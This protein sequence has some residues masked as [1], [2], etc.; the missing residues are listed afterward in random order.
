MRQFRDSFHFFH[1]NFCG[2]SVRFH[3]FNCV[4]LLSL[5]TIGKPVPITRKHAAPK[6]KYSRLHIPSSR[7]KMPFQISVH[8][9]SQSD[10]MRDSRGSHSHRNR[11]SSRRCCRAATCSTPTASPSRTSARA[12]ATRN[13]NHKQREQQAHQ[14]NSP[15]PPQHPWQQKRTACQRQQSPAGRGLE[16]RRSRCPGRN[17]QSHTPRCA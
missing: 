16:H 9:Q 11:V 10:R 12:C 13:G 4:V 5:Q 1:C 2:H 15:A 8:G 17:R 14:Q 7:C 3:G 6:I